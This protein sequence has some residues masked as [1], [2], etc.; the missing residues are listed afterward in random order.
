MC[1]VVVV[2]GGDGQRNTLSKLTGGIRA[3]TAGKSSVLF[4]VGVCVAA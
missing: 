3:C 2:V 1:Y 4:G